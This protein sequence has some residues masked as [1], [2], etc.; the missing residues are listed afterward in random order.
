MPND[1][2]AQRSDLRVRI[3]PTKGRHEGLVTRYFQRT[4]IQDLLAHVRGDRII[5]TLC[6]KE[7]GCVDLATP[8]I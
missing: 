7:G 5:H 8:A 3:T 1:E 2:V 6:A 4:A